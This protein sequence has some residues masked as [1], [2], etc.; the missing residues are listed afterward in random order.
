ML[1]FKK[2]VIIA[3]LF[4]IIPYILFAKS[5]EIKLLTNAHCEGCKVKIEKA[6]KKI[7]G[8]EDANLD[9]NTKIAFVKYE[10]EKVDVKDF[11]TALEKIGYTAQLYKEGEE[12]NLTKEKS[13]CCSESK[14]SSC[15]KNKK[16]KT[17]GDNK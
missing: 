4:A 16:T 15:C 2:F 6:L 12:T 10:S 13:K 14:S 11:I 9:L 8:V 7:D 3:I 17:N 1:K 5:T